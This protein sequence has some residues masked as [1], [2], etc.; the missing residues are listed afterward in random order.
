MF[1]VGLTGGIGSG[2]STVA[3]I[4]ESY[5]IPR[6]DADKQAHHIYRNNEEL[7]SAVVEKFGHAVALK[8]EA[9]V[10]IDINRNALGAIVFS[11][12]D[13]LKL[14]NSLVHPAVSLSYKKWLTSLTSSTPYVI[15]EAAIL[16]ESGANVGCD[17]VITVSARENVRLERTMKRDNA[18]ESEVFSRIQKQYSDSEREKLSDHI[19]VNNPENE[20]LPQLEILHKKLIEQ[21][22]S[23]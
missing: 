6:F 10:I 13:K 15:R 2:K 8:N 3:K 12:P 9:G 1:T 17:T 18:L 4:F 5:N 11:H 7:R 22:L 23:S 19:V 20:I 14:L 16:F 21:S